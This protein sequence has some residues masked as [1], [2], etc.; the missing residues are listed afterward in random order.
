MAESIA[1]R[2][3]R[4]S[5][6]EQHQKKTSTLNEPAPEMQQIGAPEDEQ[7]TLPKIQLGQQQEAILST[8]QGNLRPNAQPSVMLSVTDRTK[9]DPLQTVHNTKRA[10]SVSSIK[11]SMGKL[12][13]MPKLDSTVQLETHLES[14]HQ[15]EVSGSL[16]PTLVKHS[17]VRNQ[18][19]LQ[20]CPFCGGYPEEIERHHPDRDGKQAHEALEKHV[21]DHLVSISMILAP[22]ETEDPDG[23]LDDSQSE[24]QRGNDSERGLDGVLN[25]YE[26][27]C[28]NDSCDCKDS[29]K[30]SVLDWSAAPG[31]LAW[32]MTD[33]QMVTQLWQEVLDEK[34]SHQREDG[35]LLDFAAK[36]LLNSS[37]RSLLTEHLEH[38]LLTFLSVDKLDKITP[39]TINGELPWTTQLLMPQI[40]QKVAS[41]AKGVFCVLVLI[42]EPTAIVQLI[43][44]GI[45]DDDLPLCRNSD[46]YNDTEY[47]VLASVGSNKRFP[48]TMSWG[49]GAQANT[50]AYIAIKEV[51]REMEFIREKQNLNIIQ[52]LQN[53]HLI[54]L[55][56]SCERGS[57]YYLLF[58]WANGGTLRDFW[59]EQNSEPRTPGLVRWALEQILGLVDGIRVLHNHNIR[60]GDIKP[61]N[62]LV[63]QGPTENPPARLVLADMGVSQFH[64]EATDL[65]ISA[66]LPAESTVFYEAPEADEGQRNNKPRPRRYDMWSAGYSS[67]RSR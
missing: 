67:E 30:N 12:P 51:R 25:N 4:F 38:R 19:A 26:L 63:F 46:D 60:H 47:N 24:A 59:E 61:Q 27:Q 41:E 33:L 64:K 37:H 52:R 58:P 39:E 66:T 23:T 14:H 13:S 8:P 65:R 45:T 56:A 21:R 57:T 54:T 31:L 32:E 20:D 9:L 5:Y 40:A 62:I 34:T 6:L 36:F 53:R 3:A 18:H 16:R 17:M 44:E 49:K 42:E 29:E 43:K 1:T 48:S 28:Q 7:T 50:E 2:R 55:L 11:I 10:E 22:A 15:K 35:T